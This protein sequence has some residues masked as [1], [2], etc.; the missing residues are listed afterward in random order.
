VKPVAVPLKPA[1]FVG[2]DEEPIELVGHFLPAPYRTSPLEGVQQMVK[3][4]AIALIVSGVLAFFWNGAIAGVGFIDEFVK[5]R[6]MEMVNR[7]MEFPAA[8]VG[9][10]YYGPPMTAMP[11]RSSDDESMLIGMFAG[12]CLLVPSAVAVWAGFGMLRLKS[13][14][15]SVIGS[16]A[17]MLGGASVCCIGGIPIGVWSLVILFKPGVSTTFR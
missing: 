17:I 14:W 10:P 7:P 12:I 8:N 4:P 2:F 6:P 9:V 13:Y 1:A 5:Q 16:I 3:A 11:S 15:V